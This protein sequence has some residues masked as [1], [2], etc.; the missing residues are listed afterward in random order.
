MRG[1]NVQAIESLNDEVELPGFTGTHVKPLFFRDYHNYNPYVFFF[2]GG[3][4]KP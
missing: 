3:G 4:V 2:W 1:H